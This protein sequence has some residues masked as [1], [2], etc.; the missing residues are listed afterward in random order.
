MQIVSE[1]SQCCGC[2]ACANVCPKQC[3]SM[4]PD[5]EGFL[6]PNIDDTLCVN[7]KKC[8]HTCPVTNK[9]SEEIQILKSY[10]VQNKNLEIKKESTSGGFFSCVAEHI[11]SLGGFVYAPMFD[12]E[13]K[14]HHK[15]ITNSQDV[16]LARGSKYV[17]S[18][19]GDCY[20]QIKKELNENRMICFAG[21]PCQVEGLI[22]VLGKKPENLVTVGVVCH[23]VPSPKVWR[24]YISEIQQ[25]YKKKVVFVNFRDKTLGYHRSGVKIYFD[26]GSSKVMTPQDIYL[27]TFFAE[28]CSRPSC[29]KCN[30]KDLGRVSD[31]TLFD[32]W[33][34]EDQEIGL[35]NK[36]AT[37]VFINSQNGIEIFENLGSNFIFKETD[38]NQAV[39]EDGI[40]VL[41]SAVP[42]VNR[43][44]FF[45]NID[46]YKLVEL[47]SQYYPLSVKQ[48]LKYMVKD[49]LNRIGILEKINGIR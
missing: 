5:E 18:E 20:R 34:A 11:L 33:N 40:M 31:F 14:V 44:K 27:R 29:Y 42:N 16:A 24:K 28:I 12:E 48:H 17:Q 35:D 6:Y 37:N 2:G 8:I 39:S 46:K 1:Y 4:M 3:I 32:A 10:V 22:K 43:R 36:G 7:C 41:H 26:D 15:K 45:D 47:Q 30:F 38:Y 23:G 21:T 9:H 49:V 19:I 13:M 25:K